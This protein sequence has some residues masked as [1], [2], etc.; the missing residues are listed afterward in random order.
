MKLARLPLAGG[1]IGI[2]R[3]TL[4]CNRDATLARTRH[5]RALGKA[6]THPNI[7]ID[8]GEALIEIVTDAQQS[9]EAVYAELLALHRYAA[10]NIGDEGLWP[11]S[12]PCILPSD[13]EAIEIGHFGRSNGARIKRLY[14]IGLGHRYG[15]AMQM[16]AGVHFNYSPNPELWQA[17]AEQDG[18]PLDRA[19]SDA[20]YMGMIRNLQRHGWLISYLFGASPAVDE[21]FA[22]ARGVLG[23]FSPRTLGWKNATSLRMSRLGYQN[24]VDFTVSFNTLDAYL[25]DLKR[26][27]RTPAPSFVYLGQKDAAGNYR[28][29]STNILQIANEYYTAARPKHPTRC[30]ELPANALHERGIAY[31]EL[32]LL[33]SN[34]YDPCGVSLAQIRFLETFMLWTLLS[35]AAAFTHSDYNEL[36][37]NRRAIACCGRDR[38]FPLSDRGRRRQAGQWADALFEQMWPIAAKLDCDSGGSDYRQALGRWRDSTLGM[39]PGLPQRVYE[40]L[41]ETAFIDWALKLQK[42][43][44][45]VLREPLPAAVLGRL[46]ALRDHS[47]SEFARIES[48]PQEA[49]DTFL[50]HYFDPLERLN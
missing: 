6:F 5:P 41:R 18:E 30:G 31:V 13:P 32:R 17:L 4:R 20:R 45:G 43:H 42:A 28:Q 9:P 33:D 3:E 40:E 26:A 35:P 12:M 14:R 39:T 47:L 46:N 10:Q 48:A 44:A 25:K 36:E 50:A 21:S 38:H 22:P 27:M 49:F 2:E 1:K 8:Y 37:H 34:P 15:R 24:K 19:Y 23:D 11:V 29:I 16:M 7:T